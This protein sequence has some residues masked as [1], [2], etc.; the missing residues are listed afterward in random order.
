MPN[1][2]QYSNIILCLKVNWKSKEHFL[3]CTLRTIQNLLLISNYV[4]FYCKDQQ[5]WHMLSDNLL[6]L[7]SCSHRALFY[8]WI[9]H[10]C[11]QLLP[12][13][14]IHVPF[15]SRCIGAFKLDF[16][17]GDHICFIILKLKK[18][19]HLVIYMLF[20]SFGIYK[21]EFLNYFKKECINMNL[22]VLYI[23]T[24]RKLNNE[25]TFSSL[26]SLWNWNKFKCK[27]KQISTITSI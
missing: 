26:K 2:S 20:G 24:V 6:S 16:V 5:N 1:I 4:R 25:V 9:L 15:D 14:F 27:V 18:I 17:R 22:Y 23:V 3:W 19:V 21:G 11:L 8:L 13:F 12:F 7:F 10:I